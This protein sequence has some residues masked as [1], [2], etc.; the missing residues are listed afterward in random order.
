[1]DV[2]QRIFCF[3]FQKSSPDLVICFKPDTINVSCPIL[4]FF[5]RNV[6][7]NYKKYEPSCNKLAL[8]HIYKL[9]GLDRLCDT[10]RTKDFVFLV[11]GRLITCG[12]IAYVCLFGW[13][14]SLAY[15]LVGILMFITII[16]VPYGRWPNQ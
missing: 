16:G 1:M 15:F 6:G 10:W 4:L 8:F 3:L 9:L 12:N 14:V 11:S 5:F 2:L 7:L 13:W